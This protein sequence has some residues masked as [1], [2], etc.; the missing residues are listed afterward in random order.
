MFAAGQPFWFLKP[1]R[2][3]VETTVGAADD[4]SPTSAVRTQK[5]MAE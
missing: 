2:C 4:E 1:E 5:G 3:V